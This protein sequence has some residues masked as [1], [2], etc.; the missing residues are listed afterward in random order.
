M[1][2]LDDA[3]GL[4]NSATTSISS[5]GSSASS[6]LDSGPASAL[7]SIGGAIGGLLGG[8]GSFIKKLGASV[9]LPL[10]NPLFSYASYDYVLGIA[11]I[12][13]ADANAPDT[14]YMKS[15]KYNLIAK[16]ANI[17]PSNRVQTNYGQFDFFIENLEMAAV[18]GFEKNKNTN[19][20]SIK[21]E[22][23]EPYSMGMFMMSCQVAA[24][25][26]GYT[27]WL[28]AVFLLTIDFR[29]NTETGKI[30]T[31]PN[32][33]RK[34]PM[35]LKIINSRVDSMGMIYECTAQPWNQSALSSA[36]ANIPV[37]HSVRGVTVQEILQY[38]EKSLQ[39]LLNKKARQKVYDKLVA[40]PDEYIILF[41]KKGSY[42]GQKS[43]AGGKTE[44]KSSATTSVKTSEDVYKIIGVSKDETTGLS[45]QQT[46]D[47][48]AIGTSK[49]PFSVDQK[50]SIPNGKEVELYDTAGNY[51]KRGL[52]T[53]NYDS[54]NFQFRQD[55]DIPNAINQVVLQSVFPTKVT[56]D[57]FQLSP[58]G[59]KTL[60]RIHTK[61]YIVDT[62]AN[63]G[64]T[65]EKPCIYVYEVTE[66]DV[67]SSST[68]ANNLRPY[69]L[70]ALKKHAVKQYDYL[71]TGKNVDIL[72]FDIELNASYYTKLSATSPAKSLDPKTQAQQSQGTTDVSVPNQM[73]KGQSADTKT[74][75]VPNSA[76]PAQTETSSDNKG[77]SPGE[78]IETRAA[79]QFFDIVTTGIE[80]TT[81]NM[82]II[83]DPYY[84][85][86]SGTGNY[87]SQSTEY[88]NLTSDGTVN[89]QNG[90]VDI[91]INFRSPIDI[92]QSTGLYNFGS[93]T[94]SA[95]VVHFS[96]LYKIQKLTSHFKD[97][98]F[99]QNIV[100]V[101]RKGQESSKQ[102]AKTDSFNVGTQKTIGDKPTNDPKLISAT[103]PTG[104]TAPNNGW[105]EG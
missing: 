53:I 9:K 40:Y 100:G 14:S 31:I 78:S 7:S 24:Q 25:K 83:G 37:D 75:V 6:L 96:G 73:P 98:K 8:A 86:Q 48:N 38:G 12:P 93:G 104:S 91:L 105:G 95:P 44:V 39:A 85:A 64:Y 54:S 33:S 35:R 89:W 47:T 50:G 94:K 90:E 23:R 21:F 72:K 43:G 13:P 70:D 20:A 80:Q 45:V 63:D 22:I 42:S 32:T 28:S 51:W 99:T 101:R 58:E 79:R 46:A 62:N 36:I 3:S 10:P 11:V 18:I 102:A 56:L 88:H 52:N 4:I 26:A 69:G 27:N 65:G 74:P 41:P 92:N 66:Y 61:V 84:I 34:I 16:S 103:N 15:K 71:Y 57:P 5:L 67:G 17:D 82:E 59:Y 1:G 49:M 68:T 2:L 29:G 87:T 76:R 55:S 19:T 60:W 81:L 30:A 77:G 97:G